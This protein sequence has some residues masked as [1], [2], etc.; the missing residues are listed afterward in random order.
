MNTNNRSSRYPGTSG[1]MPNEDFEME[2]IPQFFNANSDH[3]FRPHTHNFYQI[4]WFIKGTGQHYVD[5]HAYPV[6]GNMLFFV[7]PGQIH[8]FD[9]HSRFEG[10]I[11]HFDESFLSDEWQDENVF[12]KYNIFNAFDAKPCFKVCDAYVKPLGHIIEDI[13][14]ELVHRHDFAHADYLKHLVKLFL[15]QIQRMGRRDGNVELQP[16]NSIHC[17]FVKFRQLIENHYR[18]MHTT[19]EYARCMNVTSKTLYNNVMEVEHITPLQ[20]IDGRIILEAKRMLQHTSL[21][22]KE[23]AFQ[24]GFDDPSYFVKF[25]KRQAGCLPVEFRDRDTDEI[26][27]KP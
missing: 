11:I 7:S 24:L 19:K 27:S 4:V 21:K 20:M 18:Q 2:Q 10:I 15:I 14:E 16:N 8:W 6:E 13:R 1:D 17:N 22:V 5:F 26:V 23:I 3:P 25:F 9:E 12:L